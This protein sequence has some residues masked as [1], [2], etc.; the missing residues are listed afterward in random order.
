MSN[1]IYDSMTMRE[2]AEYASLFGDTD[3]EVKF[4]TEI[5]GLLGEIERLNNYIEE[6]EDML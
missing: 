6:L 4:A 1:G 3:L 2:K 5:I